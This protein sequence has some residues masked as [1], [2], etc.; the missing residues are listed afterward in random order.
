[1]YPG[2]SKVFKPKLFSL[3]HRGIP[4]EQI[5]KDITAG[6]IVGI[7]ALPLA[8]A[9][10]IAS[11][12][13]PEKGLYTAIVGGFIVSLLGGSRVQIAGPTGAFIVVVYGV[14]QEYGVAGLTTATFIAGFM[15]ILMGL[16]RL[17]SVLKYIPY[18]LVVGFTTGIA[19]IIASAQV[20]DFFGLEM[21]DVPADFVEKWIAYARHFSH[22]NWYAVG[23]ATATALLTLHF[24]KISSK[25]PGSLVG[26]L[27]S[28]IVVILCDWPVETIQSRFGGI[29]GSLPEAHTPPLNYETIRQLFAPAFTIAMLGAIE[30]LLSAVV[31]DGMIGGNHRSNTELIAQGLANIASAAVGGIPATGAIARTATNVKNGGRTP[32]AGIMHALTLLLIMLFFGSWAKLIPMASLA[33]VLVVVAWN[34]SEVHAFRN[35]LRGPKHDRIILLTAFLLT[36]L[37]DLTLAIEIGV[38]LA[39]FLFM[40]RMAKISN[41]SALEEMVSDDNP[42]DELSFVKEKIEELPHTRIFEIKGPMFFGAAQQFR[43]TMRNIHDQP[44]I[45]IIRLRHVPFIDATG[46]HTLEA[47]IEDFHS[48]HIEVILSGTRPEVY[49]ELERFG[50][51]ERIGKENVTDHISK[52]IYVAKKYLNNGQ[53]Q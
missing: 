43:E 24:S 50:L 46:L 42:D 45:V 30:S 53:R 13:S 16:A 49:K 8:I 25:I 31:A 41:V 20:R 23:I 7:V 36:V 39:S 26:I 2:I 22:V 12:V 28:T 4:R 15:I 32:I 1:M 48:R 11:G 35:I 9:F 40:R 44:R 38:V 19:L 10:A 18:S 47:L 51:V 37:V 14:V 29:P 33:G 3:I 5:I 52:A 6:I 27:L 34:M 21:Q 17:G